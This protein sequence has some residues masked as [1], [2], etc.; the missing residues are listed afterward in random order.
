MEDASAAP[1]AGTT[2]AETARE[3]EPTAAAGWLAPGDP[4]GSERCAAC[5]GTLA[6]RYGWCSGCRMALC[7]ACGR[8][9]FCRPACAANGCRAGLC[10]REVREGVLS[11]RWGLAPE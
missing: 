2:D 8:R 11:D 5:G 3:R 6:G 10:V 4:D 9:H 1:R 7:F